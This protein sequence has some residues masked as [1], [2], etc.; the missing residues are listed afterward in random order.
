MYKYVLLLHVVGATIWTGGHIV[1]CTTVLPKALRHK[2]LG[3][4][5]EFEAM[6]ERIAM[7][8]L[9]AQALTGLWMAHHF[10]ASKEALV[11]SNPVLRLVVTK[12]VLLLATVALA[13]HVRLR[14]MPGLNQ[15]RLNAFAVHIILVTV[16]SVLFVVTGLS[17]RVGSFF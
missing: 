3:A 13:V 15:A 1:L 14:I 5:L 8:A 12:L 6:F 17:F 2:A 11:W 16:L 7:P 9:A 10:I 4:L